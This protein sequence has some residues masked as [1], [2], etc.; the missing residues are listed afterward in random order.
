KAPDR[1]TPALAGGLP[2]S[3][4]RP[5]SHQGERG[6]QSSCSPSPLVGEGAGGGGGL[7]HPSRSD[8]FADPQR[9]GCVSLPP[10]SAAAT[11]PYDRPV[12]PAVRRR[13]PLRAPVGRR[14]GL[15][16]RWRSRR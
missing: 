2:P 3:P 13:L 9:P 12:G 11:M 15:P 10:P 1:T 4:P 5:L 7:S 8:D 16:A 14:G 6:S